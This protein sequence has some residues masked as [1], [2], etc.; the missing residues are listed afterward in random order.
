[1]KQ[2]INNRFSNNRMKINLTKKEKKEYKLNKSNKQKFWEIVDG[3]E[4]VG[5]K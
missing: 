1:M 3:L 4:G 5:K 2:G